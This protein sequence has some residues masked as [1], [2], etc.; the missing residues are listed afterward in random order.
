MKKINDIHI[1]EKQLSSLYSLLYSLDSKF[2][3]EVLWKFKANILD[4]IKRRKYPKLV[5]IIRK[6]ENMV[7]QSKNLDVYEIIR[8][9]FKAP[10][11]TKKELYL[12]KLYVGAFF[13]STDGLCWCH[14]KRFRRKSE[15]HV[16][17]FTYNIL[18]ED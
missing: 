18:E 7:Y 1:S 13:G 14:T 2:E 12:L 15:Y 6:I 17:I 11:L 3:N 5:T 8:L 10:K 9:N 4:E 16:T